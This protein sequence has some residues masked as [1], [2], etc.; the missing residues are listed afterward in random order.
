MFIKEQ[1]P[2]PRRTL[3]P[4]DLS[5][6]SCL[7]DGGNLFPLLP[8]SILP[9]FDGNTSMDIQRKSKTFYSPSEGA[10]RFL[11][12]CSLVDAHAVQHT[13][14]Q[15]I[16]LGFRIMKMIAPS[17]SANR[18]AFRERRGRRPSREQDSGAKP[19]DRKRRTD[20]QAIEVDPNGPRMTCLCFPLV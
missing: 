14:P 5:R 1:P 17:V 10:I 8:S 7:S 12:Y 18:S 6:H 15:S 20:A 2:P 16:T 4:V 3:A 13:L 19:M 11:R 9:L